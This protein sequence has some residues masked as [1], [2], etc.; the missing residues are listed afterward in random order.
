MKWL[1]TRLK[2]NGY[3]ENKSMKN[4]GLITG[5]SSGIGKELARIHASKGRDLV[6]VARRVDL[7]NE[8]KNELQNQFGVKV[9]VI[10]ADLMDNQG[11][12][13]VFNEVKKRGID[14][15]YLFNNAGLGG[16]GN[17]NERSLKAESEMIQ[18]NIQSLMELTHL[19]LPEM[20]ARGKG[21]IMNTSST[22]GY[23]PGPLQTNYFATK[24][25]VNSFSNGLDQEVRPFGVT[26][27]A[28]CPGPVKTGFESAAGMAGSGLFANA[29]TAQ[30][31]A[32]KGYN[33]MEKGKLNVI[34]DNILKI[35]IIG[36][37]PFMPQRVILKAMQKMQRV[38]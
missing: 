2:S 17:F 16:Y 20:I 7:L 1:G 24:A 35:F 13:L 34:T 3:K 6:L 37:L 38:K 21:K 27:T 23:M 31:T 30:S 12:S 15:H 14:V 9:E 11:P 25:F 26:V 10:G 5:A 8:L 4:T 33:G 29:A 28:L 36:I 19:F 18:L 22:A 32:M